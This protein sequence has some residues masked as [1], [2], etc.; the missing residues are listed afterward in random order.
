MRKVAVNFD[1]FWVSI[2]SFEK[3][4]HNHIFTYEKEHYGVNLGFF[5]VFCCLK[6]D[7]YQKCSAKLDTVEAHIPI[8][9]MH[10]QKRTKMLELHFKGF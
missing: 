6:A 10:I 3:K 1:I 5:T 8:L 2:R 9:Y 7:I 4:L